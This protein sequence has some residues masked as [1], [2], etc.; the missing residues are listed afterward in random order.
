MDSKIGSSGEMDARRDGLAS[1][2]WF[3]HRLPAVCAPA[4]TSMPLMLHCSK[5]K[6]CG[7]VLLRSFCIGPAV[8]GMHL[9]DKNSAD[10]LRSMQL[11][12]MHDHR[13]REMLFSTARARRPK[14]NSRRPKCMTFGGESRPHATG[15]HHG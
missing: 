11:L 12:C 14:R 3:M 13:S 2:S 8:Q 9:G 4:H 7:E 15:G 5:S 1:N 6:L 10:L